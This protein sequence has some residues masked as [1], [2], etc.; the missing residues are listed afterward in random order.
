MHLTLLKLRC[1]QGFTT[2]TL[3]GVLAVGGLL[4]AAGFAA[5]DPD[6]SL[7]RED[8]DYKQSYGA[9][10]SGLQWYLNSLGTDNN[11]YTLCRSGT[12]AARTRGSGATSLA[13]APVTPSSSCPRPAS[14]SACPAT[15]T[16]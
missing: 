11:Y 15:S 5:V 9:A 16:R 8:Q 2:I 7:S 12:A 4:L 1:Q 6:I 13:R 10:E 14:P 3:M